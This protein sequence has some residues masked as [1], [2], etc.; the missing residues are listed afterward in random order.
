MATGFVLTACATTD[1]EKLHSRLVCSVGDWVLVCENG[2]V[3]VDDCPD[4]DCD[5]IDE[6][7]I[8]I[9]RIDPYK[10]LKVDLFEYDCRIV[11][12][13]CPEIKIVFNKV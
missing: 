12:I 2:I 13:N 1:E 9:G 7:Y 6:H 3:M 5:N 8:P 11:E 4:C 10:L